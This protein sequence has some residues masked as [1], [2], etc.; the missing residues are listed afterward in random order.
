MNVRPPAHAHVV[1]SR[2]G[3]IGSGRREG[4]GVPQ[5]ASQHVHPLR[6]TLSGCKSALVVHEGWFACAKVAFAHV[7]E[8][9]IAARQ[10]LSFD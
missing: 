9:A 6:P 5:D 3:L 4:K 10:L 8:A 1:R 2:G 7:R